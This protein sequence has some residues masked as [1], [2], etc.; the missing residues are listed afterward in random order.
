MAYFDYNAPRLVQVGRQEDGALRSLAIDRDFDPQGRRQTVGVVSRSVRT[1]RFKVIAGERC[2][3]WESS[4]SSVSEIVDLRCVTADGVELW[5]GFSGGP[6][7]YE[8]VKIDRRSVAS[9]E[10]DLPPGLMNPDNWPLPDTDEIADGFVVSLVAERPGAAAKTFPVRETIKRFRSWT[11]SVSKYGGGGQRITLKDGAAWSFLSAE[12]ASDGTYLQFS[13]LFRRDGSAASGAN[14]QPV[15][16]GRSE[17]ILR[18]PCDWYD[19]TPRLMDGG[20]KRCLAKDGVTLKRAP[21]SRGDGTVLSAVTVK[22][23]PIS[24]RTLLDPPEAF[25]AAT[26]GLPD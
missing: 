13:A 11:L 2:E 14:M 23:A 6:T 5:R 9:G 26:W 17:L 16:L 8:A 7:L 12:I 4:Q 10:V 21:W 24:F 18:E 22:R 3:I 15:P 25:S 1:G 19:M 20:E